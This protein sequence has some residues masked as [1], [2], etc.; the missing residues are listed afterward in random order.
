MTRA[1]AAIA[2]WSLVL[3]TA[4]LILLH[5]DRS[6]PRVVAAFEAVKGWR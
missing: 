6:I 4:L 3:A 2:E 5:A 1:L